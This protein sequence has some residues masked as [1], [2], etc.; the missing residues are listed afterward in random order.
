MGALNTLPGTA[1][2]L[3]A[4]E[5]ANLRAAFTALVADGDH[6]AAL[7][8]AVVLEEFWGEFSAAPDGL[9]RFRRITAAAQA[10]PNPSPTLQSWSARAYAGLAVFT[11]PRGRRP[12]GESRPGRRGHERSP[13][14]PAISGTPPPRCTTRQPTRT[15]GRVDPGGRP[16]AAQALASYRRLG[17]APGTLRALEPY[18]HISC[19]KGSTPPAGRR[20]KKGCASPAGA[21]MR[22]RWPASST[23]LGSV[24]AHAGDAERARRHFEEADGDPAPSG[25]R[26]PGD[27]ARRGGM[28]AC[29]RGD[30]AAAGALLREAVAVM[31]ALVYTMPLTLAVVALLVIVVTSYQQT[32]RA[33]PKGGGSYIVASENLGTVPGLVA[34]ASIL[35]DYVLTVAVSVSAGV[36]AL[37][38]AFPALYENRVWFAV[39]AVAVIAWGNLR[40]VR[41]SGTLFAAPVYLYLGSV[42]GLLAFGFFRFATGDAPAYTPPPD[43]PAHS[44]GVQA[45]GLFLILRAFSSGAVGLTGTEA[46]A[47]G[48]G[49]FK[50]PE[51][52]NARIVLLIM[53]TCFVTVFVGISFLASWLHIV[54]DPAEAETVNGQLTRTL[55]GIGPYYYLVQFATALLLVLAANTAFADFPR[56]AFFMARDKFLPSHFAFRGERL[57]F[58][59][60]ITVLATVAA[61]LI[62]FFQGS[63]TALIPLYTVGVFIAFTLSQAGIAVRFWRLREPRWP[64]RIAVS[65]TG[66]V[67]TA[68]VAIVVAVTKFALGAWVVLVLI[69]LL[70][71]LLLGIRRHYSIARDQLAVT[72]QDLRT[73]PDLDPHQLQHVVVIPVADLNRAAVRAVAYARSLTGQLEDGPAPAG[74]DGA[75]GQAQAHLVAVHVTDNIEEGE[76]LK[77]RWDRSGLGVDLVILESP[78][79]A[80]TGPLLAYINALER[81]QPEVTSVV[82]VLLPEYIPAHWWEHVLHTQTALRLKGALLFRPRTAVASVPYHLDD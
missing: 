19:C 54:P 12:R 51:A 23:E 16:F 42:L 82:T 50:R 62:V 22:A 29:A 60:G 18:G 77:D 68:G 3:F 49:A 32:I 67:I 15:F 74:G 45:L 4:A 47:D 80:L 39:A 17:D 63:V 24:V 73:R 44:H 48:V 75:L 71:L 64:W 20:W 66:A 41:E 30:A 33:Y 37:T 11:G 79:R 8:L 78:Y 59:N 34:G 31:A 7:R 28:L 14:A 55:V 13:R 1:S 43:D 70:V 46:V 5:H 76:A 21:E 35:T 2:R 26:E 81:Q 36:A 52:R 40:G 38:S 6:E 65:G 56:L 57:A 72:E 10:V 27:V 53:A 9:Q 61:L 69:P 25:Q 58:S